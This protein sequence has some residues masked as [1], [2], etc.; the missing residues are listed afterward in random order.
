M[1]FDVWSELVDLR[2]RIAVIETTL[3]DIRRTLDRQPTTSGSIV[4]PVALITCVV[5]GAIALAVKFF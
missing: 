4:V 1:S 5:Q 3:L 2:E